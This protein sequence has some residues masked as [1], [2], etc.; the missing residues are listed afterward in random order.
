MLIFFVVFA[1]TYLAPT[2]SYSIFYGRGKGGKW[3][4]KEHKNDAAAAIAR[5]FIK[6][7]IFQFKK[8]PI[9]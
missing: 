2:D 9:S 6:F 5:M 8:L 7:E 3:M 1:N 4:E